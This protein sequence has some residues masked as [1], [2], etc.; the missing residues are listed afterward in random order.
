MIEFKKEVNDY[1]LD[2]V[3]FVLILWYNCKLLCV[4]IWKLV[5]KVLLLNFIILIVFKIIEYVLFDYM[6]IGYKYW[7]VFVY[8]KGVRLN[9][10]LVKMMFFF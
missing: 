9:G 8:F 7:K 10:Y 2:Y 4:N 1:F 5:V 3:I 6:F